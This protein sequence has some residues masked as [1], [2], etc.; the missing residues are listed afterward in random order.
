MSSDCED[1]ILAGMVK[2]G[3]VVSVVASNG[4]VSKEVENCPSVLITFRVDVAAEG[5]QAKKIHADLLAILA[6]NEAL[7]Y[8]AIVSTLNDAC[9]I[10]SNIKLNGSEPSEAPP[11]LPPPPNKDL[12]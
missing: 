3:Y 11:Q 6:A 4:I 7:Y 9:F 12:N 2:K 10:G 1:A 5:I 8:S